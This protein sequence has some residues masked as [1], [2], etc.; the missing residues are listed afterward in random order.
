M[1]NT[2]QQ[3]NGGEYVDKARDAARDHP[4]QARSAIDKVQDAVDQ[5]T[6]GRFTSIID[7]A[8]DFLEDRIG[9]PTEQETGPEGQTDPKGQTDPERQSDPTGCGKLPG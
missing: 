8:G 7:T 5:R 4:D 6:G 9:L 3:F 1:G 2:P